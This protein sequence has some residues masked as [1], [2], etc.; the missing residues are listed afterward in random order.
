M[1]VNDIYKQPYFKWLLLLIPFYIHTTVNSVGYYYADEHYQIVEFALHILGQT[2]ANALAWEYKYELR[3]GLLPLLAAIHIKTSSFIG[4]D[5]PF[6]Q[7]LIMRLTGVVLFIYAT[8]FFMYQNESIKNTQQSFYTLAI[9]WLL[10]FMPMLARFSA[11]NFSACLLIILYV[12]CQN[13]NSKW[14]YVAI[15]AAL[16]ICVR[17]QAVVIVICLWLHT[18]IADKKINYTLPFAFL[19]ANAIDLASAFFLY[20]KLTLPLY[21]YANMTI[22]GTGPNFG[23]QPFSYYITE[24][25]SSAGYPIGALIIVALFFYLISKPKHLLSCIVFVYLTIH[26][27]MPHKELRFLFPLLLLLPFMILHLL[28]ALYQVLNK[29]ICTA[30]ICM[31]IFYS[32]VLLVCNSFLPACSPVALIKNINGLSMPQ[33]LLHLPYC[34]PYN[35]FESLPMRFYYNSGV[36]KIKINSI[37]EIP[38]YAKSYSTISLS[39]SAYQ[40]N[41]TVLNALGFVPYTYAYPPQ[42]IKFSSAFG[43]TSDNNLMLLSRKN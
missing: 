15:T 2:P 16:L 3:S 1:V 29:K 34:N 26:V 19:L 14:Y 35:P 30:I 10:W 42:I 41:A 23:E 31:L 40:S 32:T 9:A 24:I 33:H 22:S 28:K 25:F 20:H 27:I 8:S 7:A 13:K 39:Q 12:L 36:Q 43:L 37:D 4:I 5:N 21:N 17:Y 18:L 6:Q 11:E 38:G